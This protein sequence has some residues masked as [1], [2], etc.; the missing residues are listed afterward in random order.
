[1]TQANHLSR[2]SVSAVR[3]EPAP[4]W[5]FLCENRSSLDVICPQAPLWQGLLGFVYMHRITSIFQE[6][7]SVSLEYLLTK[8]SPSPGETDAC[9]W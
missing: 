1:M 3:P 7:G 9:G 8:P 6:K 5:V 4:L 2:R